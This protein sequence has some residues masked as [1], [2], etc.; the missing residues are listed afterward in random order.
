MSTENIYGSQVV[1]TFL[2]LKPELITA[3]RTSWNHK[4]KDFEELMLLSKQAGVKVQN[5]SSD[6]FSKYTN[7]LHQHIEADLSNYPYLSENEGVALATKQSQ[8]TYLVLDQIQDPHNLG[9]CL[10]SAG[11]FGVDAV[12]IP[13]RN[14]APLTAVAHKVACGATAC[15]SV[16]KV[17]NLAQYLQK[18]QKNGVWIVG[19]VASDE[20]HS[21]YK[22]DFNMPVAL[23]L[24]SEGEGMRKLTKTSCDFLTTI[25]HPQNVSSLNISVA[26]GI[27]LSEIHRQKTAKK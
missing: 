23:V 14:A 1:L 3:I 7:A 16:I 21:L 26:C 5:V 6:Y 27:Y 4:S 2:R 24:G 9:A 19:T 13:K 20:G 12:I 8:V 25:E 22:Q 17:S 11:A 10:R 15:L 18:L